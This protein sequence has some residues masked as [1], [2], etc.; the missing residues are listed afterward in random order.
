[1][2]ISI[3]T[4]ASIRLSQAFKYG[5]NKRQFIQRARLISKKKHVASVSQI[6][7]TFAKMVASSSACLVYRIEMRS[8][9]PVNNPFH[10]LSLILKETPEVQSQMTI[11]CSTQKNNDMR[12]WPGY[13]F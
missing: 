7:Q 2:K 13:A 6:V 11:L 4:A 12:K 3:Y 10:T 9:L 1:M 8:A 5:R